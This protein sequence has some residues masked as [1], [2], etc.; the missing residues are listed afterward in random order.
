[1]GGRLAFLRLLDESNSYPSGLMRNAAASCAV[2]EVIA[3]PIVRHSRH[4]SYEVKF[5]AVIATFL[6]TRSE[7][8]PSF[9][10]QSSLNVSLATGDA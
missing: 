1:M 10:P 2:L 8:S 5:V 7:S 4:N 6:Q 3:S 9:A